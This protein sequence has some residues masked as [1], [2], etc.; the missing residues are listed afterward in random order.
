MIKELIHASGGRKEAVARVFLKIK[1]E[2][3]TSIKIKISSK[4]CVDYKDY[5]PSILLQSRIYRVLSVLDELIGNLIFDVVIDVKGGGKSGQA[6]AAA[7][8]LA[9][10]LKN[11]NIE[12]KSIL[13]SN[14]LLKRDARKVERKKFGQPKARKQH[15]FS[16]R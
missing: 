11:F 10:A 13:K 2:G 15:Q 12:Y 8:A 14:G 7:H 9:K 1:N 5:F 3:N 4:K 16:K 6:G